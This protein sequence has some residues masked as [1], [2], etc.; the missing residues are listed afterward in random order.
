MMQV[1][2]E[3]LVRGIGYVTLRV[4]TGGRYAGGTS[5]DELREGALGL[6]LI[7][8]VTYIVVALSV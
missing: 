5:G 4:V 2:I 7:A 6:A 3:A 8:L 1:L